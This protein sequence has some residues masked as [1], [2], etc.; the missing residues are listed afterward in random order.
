MQE[1]GAHLVG[2]HKINNLHQIAETEPN[3]NEPE[4]LG[5]T[6]AQVYLETLPATSKSIKKE[7]QKRNFAKGQNRSMLPYYHPD[8]ANH[9]DGADE[10]LLLTVAPM[11]ELQR[12]SP[13]K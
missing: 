2:T 1:V 10:E 13:N 5:G 3:L 4:D 6:Q 12:Q 8:G 7:I 11:T 9:P